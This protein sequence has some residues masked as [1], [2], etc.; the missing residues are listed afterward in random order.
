M[1]PIPADS[2]TIP[3][4]AGT[5]AR[6]RVALTDLNTR[7]ANPP[8][9]CNESRICL[10]LQVS[11]GKQGFV[12]QAPYVLACVNTRAKHAQD[13]GYVK[14]YGVTRVIIGYSKLLISPKGEGHGQK[15]SK[16][17]RYVTTIESP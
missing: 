3:A 17:N 2:A 9:L 4:T 16:I 10:C 15:R 11:I 8:T 7:R 14:V 6:T 13:L 5:L 1:P 12:I